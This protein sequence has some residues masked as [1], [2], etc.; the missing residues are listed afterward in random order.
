MIRAPRPHTCFSLEFRATRGISRPPAP[1]STPPCVSIRR[2][3]SLCARWDSSCSPAN[4]MISRA[5]SSCAP[6]RPIHRI[7]P[8]KVTLRGAILWIGLNGAH[9]EAAR[10]IILFAGEQDESHLAQSDLVLRIETQGGVELGA[11][12][13]E[14]PLVARNSSEKHVWGR[15]ARIILYSFR[16]F[17]ARP[18]ALSVLQGVDSSA[19]SVAAR[20]AAPEG[21]PDPGDE[22]ENHCCAN[23][24]RQR[25]LRHATSR[26]RRGER[27]LDGA[28]TDTSTHR[29]AA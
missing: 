13:R 16:E 14:I 12:G 7:A 1:S 28:A 11:G 3:R 21:E 22:N 20:P 2:T 17:A 6:F 5:D 19:H 9:E 24:N 10:E 23:Q 8:R 27:M 15:G 18:F 26:L 4:S 29:P 25:Q